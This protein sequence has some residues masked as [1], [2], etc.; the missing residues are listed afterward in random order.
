[1][2]FQC[3]CPPDNP[4]GMVDTNLVIDVDSSG[5]DESGS[6]QE[7]LEVPLKVMGHLSNVRAAG[8]EGQ[9]SSSNPVIE[10]P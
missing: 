4:N 3:D 9:S 5:P 2:P 10:T 8:G 1:M 7:Q 6:E